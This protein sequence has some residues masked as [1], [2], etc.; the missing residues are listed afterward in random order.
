MQLSERERNILM[1]GGA[2]LVLYLVYMLGIAPAG[3]KLDRMERALTTKTRQLEQIYAQKD[4]FLEHQALMKAWE[5]KIS[6]APSTSLNTILDRL[7][8]EAGIQDRVDNILPKSSPPNDFFKE[9]SVEI[10]FR[11]VTPMELVNFLVKLE[12]HPN[13]LVVRR[14]QMKTDTKDRSRLR[15][16]RIYVSTFKPLPSA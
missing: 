13:L 15:E 9:E 2:C 3:R 8:R 12:N 7:A 11:N 6:R 5:E 16:I 1:L 4:A 14:L 10:I